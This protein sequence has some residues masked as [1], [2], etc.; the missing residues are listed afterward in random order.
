M[1]NGKIAADMQAETRQPTGAP[2]R[3]RPFTAEEY[4]RLGE[5]GIPHEDDCVELVD[6]DIVR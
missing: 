1:P 6:G 2:V 4:H 3:R 5:V